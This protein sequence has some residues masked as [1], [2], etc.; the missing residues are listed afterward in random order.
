MALS[1]SGG[2]ERIGPIPQKTSY[3]PLTNSELPTREIGLFILFG[4]IKTSQPGVECIGAR[5]KL[6]FYLQGRKDICWG[7]NQ[8]CLPN[9]ASRIFHILS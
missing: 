9:L 5:V 4:L 3:I 6:R 8:E 1:F 2:E 7:E